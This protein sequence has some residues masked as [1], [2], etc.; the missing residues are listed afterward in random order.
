[1]GELRR[2]FELYTPLADYYYGRP[3][4]PEAFGREEEWLG[5]QGKKSPIQDK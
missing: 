1:M 5:K 3:G 4:D 2:V